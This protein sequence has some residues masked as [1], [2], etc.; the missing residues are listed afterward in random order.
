MLNREYEGQDF[1]GVAKSLEILGERWT[2]LIIRDAL[3]GLRRFEEFQSSLGVARNVLTDRLNRL[4]GDLLDASRLQIGALA[5]N[6][7]SIDVAESI[8]VILAGIG[9]AADRVEVEVPS[10]LPPAWGDSAL[11]ER[12][13]DNI[14]TNA[15]RHGGSSRVRITVGVVGHEIHVCV[16]D[17]GPGIPEHLRARVM[18]PFQQFGDGR[19]AGGVGLGMSIAQGFVQAMHGRLE[20]DDTPGGGLTVLI[21]LPVAD[22]ADAA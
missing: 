19:A 11:L 22:L 2:L 18:A 4:V 8:G 6:C 1:C 17:R 3:F 13:L 12:S 7:Q 9:S 10:G 14:V 16:I 20:L 21:A 5:V 15:L